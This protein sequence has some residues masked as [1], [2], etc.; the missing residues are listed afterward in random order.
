M[1]QLQEPKH[2]KKLRIIGFSLIATGLLLIILGCFVFRKDWGHGETVANFLLW[3][4]GVF[5]AF[6]S[7]P[8]LFIGF[9]AKIA[10]NQIERAKYVQQLNQQD[11]QDIA[12]TSADISSE[13]VAKIV[14]TVVDATQKDIYCKYC[15][16]S[17]DFDS[18][19]CKNCGKEQ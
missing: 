7:A 2:L 15:G 11:L 14:K 5:V 17:I 16:T 1:S 4:P 6:F 8:C 3:V 10:K 12:N 18:R 19:F 13:P 9:S